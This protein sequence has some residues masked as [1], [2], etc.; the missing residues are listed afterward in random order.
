LDFSGEFVDKFPS[1][2]TEL[3]K[4][5]KTIAKTTKT[6]VGPAKLDYRGRERN[7]RK[8]ERSGGH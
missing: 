8:R 2:S 3:V 1:F 4:G 5:D 6:G 7:D